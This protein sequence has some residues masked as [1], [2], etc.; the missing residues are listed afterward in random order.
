MKE[1]FKKLTTLQLVGGYLVLLGLTGFVLHNIHSKTN[2]HENSVMITN[3][4][5]N[6]G[7][8]GIILKSTKNETTILTNDHVCKV[9]KGA[10]GVVRTSFGDFQVSSILESQLSDLCLLTV[11]DDFGINTK[12]SN[13]APQF[14]D[15]A[16]ISGHPALMPNVLSFGHFS[17][18][19]IIQVMTG[20][21]P[22][23]DEE[24]VDPMIGMVCGFFGGYPVIKSYESVLVTAT[25]MPGSSGS[26]VYNKNQQL[27]GVVFAGSGELGYAW[28]VPYEQVINFL[29]VESPTLK[30]QN[31][32]NIM[33]LVTSQ[34][35]SKRIVNVLEKCI[36]AKEDIIV[37]YCAILRKDMLWSK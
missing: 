35:D 3:R 2:I 16:V 24:K 11:A 36:T 8:T 21:R 31:L 27:S 19:R 13:T 10:G 26:G 1:Y 37:R 7:G 33:E 29:E 20:F 14:Y 5:M 15:K 32:D 17:G 30:R 23:T 12:V 28:T 6:H 34:D 4:A 18:R 22:C 9:V 25:I